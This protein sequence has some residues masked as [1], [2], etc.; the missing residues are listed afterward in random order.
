MSSAQLSLE[1]SE[2]DFLF[3]EYHLAGVDD[4][5]DWRAP[6]AR[7]VQVWRIRHRPKVQA[8]LRQREAARAERTGARIE[9]MDHRALAIEW[10]LISVSTLYNVSKRRRVWRSSWHPGSECVNGSS[11]S[12]LVVERCLRDAPPARGEAP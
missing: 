8:E 6:G 9:V 1:L 5:Q 7:Q 4:A 12:P 10:G 3:V 2:R 11:N